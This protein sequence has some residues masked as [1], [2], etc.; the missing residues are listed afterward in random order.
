MSSKKSLWLRCQIL[1]LLVNTLAADEKYSVLNRDNLTPPIEMQLSQ[2]Q[3]R[4]SPVLAALS[5][6]SL[7]VEHFK[8]KDDPHRFCISEIRDSENVV[9]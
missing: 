5:K 3:K 9:R 8:K 4:F 1:G 7:N 2:E 6:S